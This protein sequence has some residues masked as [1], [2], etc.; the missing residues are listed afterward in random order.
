MVPLARETEYVK[1]LATA[2]WPSSVHTIPFP[3]AAVRSSQIALTAARGS[4]ARRRRPRC[5]RHHT[6]YGR[7]RRQG[8]DRRRRRR[9]RRRRPRLQVRLLGCFAR[10]TAITLK[11]ATCTLMKT[12]G[13]TEYAKMEVRDPYRM[14]TATW[15]PTA[16][17]ADLGPCRRCR[18]CR[19]RR[20]GCCAATR[21][22]DMPTPVPAK[23][24]APAP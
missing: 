9:R 14:N 20:H 19:R 12:M 23:M 3:Y 2:L 1:T 13:A 24:V 21:A 7:R 5:C 11:M 6:G 4:C 8:R 22:P 17:T 18:R 10:I 16:S 15:A